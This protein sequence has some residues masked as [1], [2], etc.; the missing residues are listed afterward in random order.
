[1]VLTDSV[2]IRR[3][4]LLCLVLLVAAIFIGGEQPGAGALFPAPWDKV[5]HVLA[6]G[7]IAVLAGMAFPGRALPIVVLIAVSIGAADEIHQIFLPGRQA[8]VDDWL[9]DL[10]GSLLFMPILLLLRRALYESAP[11]E[12]R[13]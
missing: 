12:L 5:V 7:T 4:S 10:V 3:V 6:Y 1:M 9:A 11:S 8:G 13:K 2:L